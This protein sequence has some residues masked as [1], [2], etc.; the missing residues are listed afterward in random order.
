[1][2]C[3][4]V[5]QD[6]RACAPAHWAFEAMLL[7]FADELTQSHEER[8]LAEWL[9]SQANG[10]HSNGMRRLD[11]RELTPES[12]AL[13][14]G[15]V[16]RAAA[17]IGAEPVVGWR[18]RLQRMVR[19]LHSIDAGEAPDA[20]SDTLSPVAPTGLRRGPGWRCAC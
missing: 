19:M 6:G 1:M 3:L 4:I 14:L 7:A 15:A 5:L 9:R 20:I 10:V 18:K 17:K 11:V 12:R 13:F 8:Q 16:H 2:S